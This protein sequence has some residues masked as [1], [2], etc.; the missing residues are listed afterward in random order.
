MS[1]IRYGRQRCDLQVSCL[2]P[3]GTWLIIIHLNQVLAMVRAFERNPRAASGPP[4]QPPIVSDGPRSWV[5]KG[6]SVR[7]RSPRYTRCASPNT[8]CPLPPVSGPAVHLSL[9][10]RSSFIHICPAVLVH[11]RYRPFGSCTVLDALGRRVRTRLA[12]A[13]LRVVCPEGR[14][15]RARTG[16][17]ESEPA[18]S[19]F[20]NTTNKH[21]GEEGEGG[22]RE[23]APQKVLCEQ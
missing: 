20:W 12:L 11:A 23:T 2:T 15:Q 4:P 10:V 21:L 6:N 19:H 13:S 5:D 18:D 8:C 7:R 9:Q 17:D 3:R 14:G 16:R 1:C 22:V